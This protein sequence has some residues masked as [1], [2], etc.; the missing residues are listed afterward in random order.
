MFPD[1]KSKKM[2]RQSLNDG[3]WFDM[4]SSEKFEEKKQFN[5]KNYISK[6]TDDQWEHE[7]LY[8]TKGG[9]WVLHHWSQWEG[10]EEWWEKVETASAAKWLIKNEYEP[11]DSCRDEYLRQEI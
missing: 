3:S 6:A 9:N 11:H 1:R 10:G 4:D 8:R 5:G 7:R 2:K